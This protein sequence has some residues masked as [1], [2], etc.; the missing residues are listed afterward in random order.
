MSGLFGW[1]T[2]KQ[3]APAAPPT[4]APRISPSAAAEVERWEAEMRQII[5]QKTMTQGDKVIGVNLGSSKQFQAEVEDVIKSLSRSYAQYKSEL[6]KNKKEKK[7]NRV[8][9]ANFQSNLEVMVDVSNL[10]HSYMALFQTLRDE[11][12][13]FNSAISNS[14]D[15]ND[16]NNSLD[17][18]QK[19]TSD[20][21]KTLQQ[22]FTSQSS[23]LKE[24]YS[25]HPELQDS[26]AKSQRVDA[27]TRDIQEVVAN[28]TA[29][30]TQGGAKKKPNKPK[31]SPAKKPKK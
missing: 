24:Y 29:A 9:A 17:Y 18:L 5:A 21:I 11:I 8:L 10:L 28:A 6:E 22:M 31:K 27:A 26:S 13:T 7:M 20:R 15:P 16:P 4:A 2:G 25:Q 12:H 1:L 14:T 23:F 30:L 3:A 19:L